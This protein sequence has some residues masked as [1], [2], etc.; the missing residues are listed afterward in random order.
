MNFRRWKWNI[1]IFLYEIKKSGKY[2][3][4]LKNSFSEVCDFLKNGR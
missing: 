2:F 4:A 3:A 1:G